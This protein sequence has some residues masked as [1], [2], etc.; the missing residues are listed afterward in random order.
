MHTGATLFPQIMYFLPWKSFHRFV[1]RYEGDRRVRTLSCAEHF[2]VWAFTQ[3][4]YRES[5]HDIE[6]VLSAQSVKP[7]PRGQYHNNRRAHILI[8]PESLRPIRLVLAPP[9]LMR[10]CDSASLRAE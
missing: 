1:A 10:F 4:T 8:Q 6:T 2:R 9:R 3:L 5:L 7:V